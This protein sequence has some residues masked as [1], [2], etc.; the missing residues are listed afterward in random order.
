MLLET[1]LDYIKCHPTKFFMP[2]IWLL[3]GKARLK[4]KLAEESNVDVSVLPYNDQVLKFIRDEK[5]LGRKIVLATA[6]NNVYAQQIANHLNVF[7]SV[8]SSDGEVNFSSQIK[9]DK[10][11]EEYGEKGFDYMGNSHDDL[12]VWKSSI[13][14]HVVNPERGVESKVRS[15]GNIGQVMRDD[16]NHLKVWAQQ[17]RLHQWVKNLLLFVPLLASHQLNDV[18]LLLNG[19]FAF[20]FFGLCASSV[21]LL[22]DLFDLQDDRHHAKK[23][24]RPVAFGLLSI[25]SVILVLPLILVLSF[26]ASYILLPLE[27]IKT[28]IVYYII[29][30]AYSM[31]LKRKMMVDVITLAILYTI[32]IVAGAFAFGLDLTYWMLAFSMFIFLSLALV[33]R[34]AELLEAKNSGILKKTRGRDYYPED[35]H[36]ISSLGGSAGYI[37]VMVLALY[38]QELSTISLYKHHEFIWLACP[39]LLYWVSRIWLLTHRGLMNDDPVIFAIK[40]RISLVVGVLFGVVFWIAT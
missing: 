7:D 33:K 2:V 9:R 23:R 5:K 16:A 36:M 8:F 6:S 24:L 22:N 14:A 11:I 27:F 39:L 10:L 38:I 32:R 31:Y 28:L 15:I 26:V 34:Y 4:E 25:K 37:S 1:G 30:L 21:Y 20:I 35:L 17:L 29:T 13:V 18:G 12:S 40:D 3:L 19:F